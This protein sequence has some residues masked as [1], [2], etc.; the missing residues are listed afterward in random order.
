MA[1][2]DFVLKSLYSTCSACNNKPTKLDRVQGSHHIM[3]KPGCLPVSI[4]VHGNRDIPKG[5][6]NQLL[7]ATDLKG[8]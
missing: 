8:R 4:P 7:K 3:V 6:L 2:G 5:T 1:A